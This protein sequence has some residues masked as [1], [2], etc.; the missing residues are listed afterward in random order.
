MTEIVLKIVDVHKSFGSSKIING[1]NL[2]VTQNERH[3]IIGPNGAGK[4]TLFNL[5]SG[6][7][8]VSSGR[9]ELNGRTIT[10]KFPHQINRIGL[11]RSFQVTNIF[12]QMSVF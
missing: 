11:C 7:Y 3:A 2:E 1:V 5:I 12:P 10:N 9:I 4:S 6:Y 8:E